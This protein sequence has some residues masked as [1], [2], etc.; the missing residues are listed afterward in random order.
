ML[1]VIDNIV[2]GIDCIDNGLQRIRYIEAGPE[3]MPVLAGIDI[4]EGQVAPVVEIIADIRADGPAMAFYGPVNIQFPPG[5]GRGC[6]V[7]FIGP[8]ITV[9]A[10]DAEMVS[11]PLV[12][13]QFPLVR[14]TGIGV[15][16]IAFGALRLFPRNHVEIGVIGLRE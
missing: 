5:Q 6:G 12:E 14:Q 7:P 2:V 9:R 11:E 10:A 13:R 8:G 16:D 1:V 15:Q 3:G 4:G